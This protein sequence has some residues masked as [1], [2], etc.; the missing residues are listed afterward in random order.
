[1]TGV[2]GGVSAWSPPSV[3]EAGLL[4]PADWTARMV[5][6]AADPAPLLR[7][8]FQ[9]N[10]KI[11]RARLYATAHG[12][13]QAEING[14]PVGDEA[15][16]PGWTSYHRRLRYQTYDVTDRLRPGDN[17][18]GVTLADGWFRGRLAS[19]SQTAYALALEFGLLA[20]DAQRDRAGARPVETVRANG[21]RIATGF[22]G[23]PLICD[24]LTSAGAIDDAYQLLTQTECPS[25]LYPVT[26]GATTIWERWDS[27]LPDGRV[28]PAEMTSFNHY[29]LGAVADW[30]HRA[31]GGLAP[32]APGYRVIEVAPRPG[33]GL[34]W[35]TTAHVTPY[36]RAEVAWRRA[37]GRL[38]VDVRVPAGATAVVRLPGGEPVTVGCGRHR[39]ESAFRD[40][41]DDPTWTPPTIS[42]DF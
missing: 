15:F 21:H 29:A 4:R 5:T 2:D 39:F 42:T 41:A 33:G 3:V 12:L 28:N 36:G 19:D 27:M 13:Y 1:V 14:Q 16:A 26:M 34:S 24:A 31:V 20:D 30:L 25:W 6:P 38:T 23:T 37:G 22:L 9:I 35:A 17:A 7:R 10:G 11:V 40:A 32:G 8:D 18:I